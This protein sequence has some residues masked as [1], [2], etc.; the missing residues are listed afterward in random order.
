MN[1]HN[2]AVEAGARAAFQEVNPMYTIG[3]EGRGD[4]EAIARA[5]LEAA[6]PFIRAE[7]LREAAEAVRD[8][9]VSHMPTDPP[10]DTYEEG[11]KHGLNQ[12]YIAANNLDA[13]ARDL[14]P[15]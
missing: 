11:F 15:S 1:I 12:G 8:R 6:A 7:A 4:W 14:D 10:L 3:C 13:R 9:V 2:K 5:V